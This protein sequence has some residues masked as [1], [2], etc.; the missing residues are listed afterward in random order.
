MT[1]F[2]LKEKVSQY[3]LAIYLKLAGDQ[4]KDAAAAF[5]SEFITKTARSQSAASLLHFLKQLINHESLDSN[6]HTSRYISFYSTLDDYLS[7]CELIVL[8]DIAT[9]IFE[10]LKGPG[11]NLGYFKSNYSITDSDGKPHQVPERISRIMNIIRNENMTP[12]Q[13]LEKIKEIKI[14]APSYGSSYLFFNATDSST[15]E[16]ISNLQCD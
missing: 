1:F 9:G 7:K 12:N 2:D 11:F 4:E 16:F 10:Q 6:L 3:L 15:N 13:R 8:D 5:F 14:A